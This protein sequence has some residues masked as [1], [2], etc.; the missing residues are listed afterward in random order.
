VACCDKHAKS[1]GATAGCTNQQ[2]HGNA[3][4]CA[5]PSPVTVGMGEGDHP[6]GGGRGGGKNSWRGSN[7][8]GPR[9][10]GLTADQQGLFL[11]PVAAG[12]QGEG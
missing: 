4:T 3:F 5:A 10:V 11:S 6:H 2:G 12:I 9:R 7:A 8:T 1:V